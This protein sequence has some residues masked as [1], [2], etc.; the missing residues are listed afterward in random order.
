MLINLAFLQARKVFAPVPGSNG[1]KTLSAIRTAVG[2]ASAFHSAAPLLKY[3]ADYAKWKEENDLM[4]SKKM[5][6]G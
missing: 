6:G 2:I 5:Y 1:A 4:V 3:H